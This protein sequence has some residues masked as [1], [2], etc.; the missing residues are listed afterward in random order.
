VRP[1]LVLRPQPGNDRTAGRLRDLGLT[2]RQLP[3]FT[4]RALDWTVP[5]PDGFDALMLTSAQA[6][7]L[8]GPGLRQL[9]NLPV[10]AV[11]ERTAGAAKRAGLNVSIVGGGDALAAVLAAR[12]AG[13]TRLL[14]LAG[15]ERMPALDGVTAVP[16][17]AAD[18][19]DVAVGTLSA[20]MH[21]RTAEDAGAVARSPTSSCRP[22]FEPKVHCGLRESAVDRSAGM[23]DRDRDRHDEEERRQI[24]LLAPCRD[25]GIVVLLHSPRAAR[26]FADLMSRD[27][28]DRASVRIAAL[29]AAVLASAGPGWA[30]AVAAATP[31][32]D[33]LCSV[34]AFLAHD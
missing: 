17:Y 23:P 18:E 32:D 13:L 4:A 29:S 22:D 26:R 12:S 5:E 1:A 30:D 9:A 27:G 11:G 8:A 6:V 7:R 10:V 2:V 16:V 14:H 15:R 21:R 19:M 34:A 25:G 33:A 31:D 20:L 3:L 28:V 24:P